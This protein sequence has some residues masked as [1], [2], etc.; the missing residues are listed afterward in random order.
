MKILERTQMP[1]G[2]EIQ[3]EERKYGLA[4]AAYPIAKR[5]DV[6]GWFDAGEKFLLLIMR[7]P[8]KKYFNEDVM[9]DFWALES[10]EK[11]LADLMDYFWHG[12][13]DAYLLGLLDEYEI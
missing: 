2:T 10:G 4:I 3:L 12:M 8:S 13:N 11:D 7:N 5:S 6:S 9:A 1:D